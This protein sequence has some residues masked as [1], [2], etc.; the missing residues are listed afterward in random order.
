[1]SKSL[2]RGDVV[3]ADLSGEQKAES[4]KQKAPDP[5]SRVQNLGSRLSSIPVLVVSDTR[6]NDRSG[7]AIVMP[8]TKVRPLAGE[9]FVI[10]LQVSAFPFVQVSQVRV[11]ST[12]R[13]GV[14]SERRSGQEV[15]ECLQALLAICGVRG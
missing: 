3:L 9:P 5:E 10:E 8:T 14:V 11:L 6:F 13:L 2:R 1:M 4:R 12:E 15:E 7:T